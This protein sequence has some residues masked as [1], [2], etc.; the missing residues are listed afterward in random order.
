[1]R[2]NIV[3]TQQTAAVAIGRTTTSTTT[4]VPTGRQRPVK[5]PYDQTQGRPAPPQNKRQ[6]QPPAPKIYNFCKRSGHIQREC[7][8]ANGWCLICGAK[9]HEVAGCPSRIARYPVPN[10]DP[11]LLALPAPPIAAVPIQSRPPLPPQ[12]RAWQ[13]AQRRSRAGQPGRKN[14]RAFQMD[15]AEAGPTDEATHGNDSDYST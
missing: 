2:D 15:V 4:T 13:Q 11:T 5:R 14:N 7:R 10:Q 1:M 12:N 9:D 6:Q 8:R 3:A